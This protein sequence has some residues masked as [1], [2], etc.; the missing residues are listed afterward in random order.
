MK[1]VLIF[2]TA[3]FPLVGGAEI[4]IKEITKRLGKK[5]V[6][7]EFDLITARMTTHTARQEQVGKIRVFRVGIG[8]FKFNKFLLPICGLLKAWRLN[9][10]KKYDTI[11]C[12]MASQAAVAGALFKI[13]HPQLR[14]VL[15]LQ[16]GDEEEHLRRYVL[17]S[18]FL[19]KILVRPWHLLPFKKADLIQVISKYLKKRAEHNKAKCEIRIIPNGV[20][21][22][23][24]AQE[25]GEEEILAIKKEINKKPGDI[26]LLHT[27]RL[28]RK[29]GL[30]DVIKALKYMDKKVKF[31]SIGD[32]EDLAKLKSLA[33]EMRVSER[34]IFHK[35]VDNEELP[36]YLRACD[37][38]IRPSLS[39]GFGNS[40]IEAMAAG[41]PVIATPVGGIVDFLYDP[42]RQ[43]DRAPTGLFC[44]PRDTA[45]IALAVKRYLNDK[46]LRERIVVNAW[47]MVKERYSWD[48]VA[49]RMGEVF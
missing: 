32:G 10:Q 22:R 17:G 20:D 40:F 3:Y 36:K 33:N 26:Y 49:R 47:Q 12:M 8:S 16:E 19:Y 44:Q 2:S 43:P 15:T 27:G 13:F 21:I 25:F 6:D 31:L 41:L 14:L 4:A 9:K 30:D 37:I 42:D 28:T 7:F 23:R 24:F 18:G 38:F 39:E 35:F 48:L 1:R 29:N 5:G 45:S 34:V 11:W 46:D